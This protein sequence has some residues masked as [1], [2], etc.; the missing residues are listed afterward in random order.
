MTETVHA[1]LVEMH[2]YLVTIMAVNGMATYFILS[3]MER[4]A[5]EKAFEL[6]GTEGFLNIRLSKIEFLHPNTAVKWWKYVKPGKGV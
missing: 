1:P 6:A 5:V 3:P 4:E 2:Y